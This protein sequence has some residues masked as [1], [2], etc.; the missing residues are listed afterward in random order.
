MQAPASNIVQPYHPSVPRSRDSAGVRHSA[1]SW[2]TGAPEASD[3]ER[4]VLLDALQQNWTELGYRQELAAYHGSSR[5][6]NAGSVLDVGTGNGRYLSEIARYF[7]GK[8]YF[9]VEP[10]A[11]L[12]D[13]AVMRYARRG[14]DLQCVSLESI[15]GRYDAV[16]LRSLLNELPCMRSALDSIAELTNV[17]GSAFI[18]EQLDSQCHFEPTPRRV[19]EFL[20]SLAELRRH[21][22]ASVGIA[23][24]LGPILRSHPAWNL[25][26]TLDLVLPSTVANNLALFEETYALTIELA[27]RTRPLQADYHALREEW[28][29]WCK[30][31]N[32]YAQAALRVM[33]LDRI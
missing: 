21:A 5:W 18:I 28:Q 1:P 12:L 9:G 6:K 2:T 32:R 19:M 20:E 14:I 29:W 23:Q 22:T 33:R 11:A 15:E 24:N 7:P 16:I 31:R 17:G 27:E 30:Q 10:D 25:S 8:R 3:D 4:V 13:R 26:V